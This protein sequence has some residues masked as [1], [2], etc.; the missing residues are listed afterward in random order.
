MSL[1]EAKPIL[2]E[3]LLH[4]FEHEA[5]QKESPEQSRQ[6]LAEKIANSVDKFVRAGEVNVVTVGSSTTQTG[7]GKIT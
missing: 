6:R 5:E 3:D 1:I 2:I 7:K 4:A